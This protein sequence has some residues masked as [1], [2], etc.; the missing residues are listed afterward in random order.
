MTRSAFTGGR[1]FK[2]TL[3]ATLLG[4]LAGCGGG[5]S[6]SP[7]AV[8]Q[9][10]GVVTGDFDNDGRLDLAVTTAFF[11]GN[12]S[13][14]GQVEVFFQDR[15]P[16]LP[17]FFS[18]KLVIPVGFSPSQLAVA[19][20][21]GD[22]LPDLAVAN[23]DSDTV[24]VI[25]NNRL[26]P[27]NFLGAVD[28]PCGIAPLS[29]A[30]GDL[31][32]DGLPDIAVAVDDGVDILLQTPAGTFVLS[33]PSALALTG[34]AF[35]VAVGDL[36]GDG[37]RDIAVSG[38]DAAGRDAVHVFFQDPLAPGAF[39]LPNTFTAGIRPNGVA[40]ADI[41]QDGLL[42]IAVANSGSSID[43]SGSTVSILLQDP[44][45]A[46]SFLHDRD[47]PTPNGTRNLAADDL[48][49]DG[50]PDIAVA[51]VVFQSQNTG[52]VSVLLQNP[53]TGNFLRQDHLNGFT[54]QSVAIGDLNIDGR[55][56]IAIQ[57]GPSILFQDPLRPGIF[58]NEVVIGP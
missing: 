43:G 27:G 6:S 54:P 25:F 19:D 40:I 26:A 21:N 18:Q 2:L 51:S 32:R 58:F 31:N 1:A 57:D 50:F 42:D 48:D 8:A 10:N 33:T 11:S 53:V 4:L 9:Q 44:L 52:L 20:L 3:A 46:R 41:D 16:A 38:I 14:S 23:T 36:D 24:S 28:F 49:G 5:G 35:S 39:F 30:I 47:I 45:L 17:G 55:P 22:G 12:L 7:A 34:G 37:I 13:L 15:A 56:D 29:V